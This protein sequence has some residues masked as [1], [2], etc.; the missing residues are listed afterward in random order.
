MK[1]LENHIKK[2]LPQLRRPAQYGFIVVR[3][4]LHSVFSAVMT[5]DYATHTHDEL[6]M[7]TLELENVYDCVNWSFVS[8]LMLSIGFGP[9][10]SCLVILSGQE[11][12]SS[13]MLYGGVTLIIG[14]LRSV[15]QNCSPSPLLFAIVFHPL[16]NLLWVYTYHLDV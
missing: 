1:D 16:L 6:I 13:V 8:G 11:A 14:I 12:V 15:R 9:H 3:N 10:I 2:Y 5:M 4:I 7:V